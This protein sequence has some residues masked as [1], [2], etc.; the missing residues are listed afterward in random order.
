MLFVVKLA[1]LTPICRFLSKLCANVRDDNIFDKKNAD[2]VNFT[3]L[4]VMAGE[5]VISFLTRWYNY[6]LVTLFAASTENVSFAPGISVTGILIG[7]FILLVGSIYG[8]ACRVYGA[9]A[10][11][12]GK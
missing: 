12:P 11:N 2:Y 10:L 4:T 8:Y 5:L 1:V 7:L 6:K 3:G 9:S